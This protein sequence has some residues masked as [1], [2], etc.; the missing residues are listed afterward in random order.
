MVKIGDMMV[1]SKINRPFFV[2]TG[3]LLVGASLFAQDLEI[4]VYTNRTSIPLNEQFELSVELSG[5]DANS[6]PQPSAP[7]IDNFAS[8]VGSGSSTNMQFINGRMSVSKTYTHHYIAIESGKFTVPAVTVNYKGKEY[9]SK[10]FEIEILKSPQQNPPIQGQ[11]RS[12]QKNTTDATE[13]LSN[14]LFLRAEVSNRNVYQ[15]EPVIV[16]YKIYYAVNVGNYGI[17]QLPN[18]VGFW[19]ED[20]ELPGRPKLY[21]EVVNGQQYRVAEIKKVALFAQGSGEK[22]LDPLIIECEV[23][24]PRKRKSRDPF[25]IFDDPFFGFN[26]TA[27]RRVA[28]NAVTINVLP[29]PGE[30]K[31][32]NFSGAVG[33]YTIDTSV[34]K[35]NVKTNEA[36]T[37]KLKLSGTGN[38]KIIPKPEVTFSSDFEVYE[39]KVTDTISRN[40]QQISGSK[41]FEYVLIP[42]FPG[43]QTIKPVTFSYFDIFTGSYKTI[44]SG[45]ID[46]DVAKG[47]EQFVNVGIGNS[48]EDVKFIGQDIRYIQMRLPE[49][50]RIGIVF[51]KSSLFYIAL[52]LPLLTL[53]GAFTYRQH[54]DKLSSD[55]AYARSRK[56][57]QMALQRLKKANYEMH[58]EHQKEF[59]SEVA[60]ALMGFIGDKLN[61]A[62][63]GLIADQ[64]YGMLRERGINKEIVS[65]YLACLQACD[66]QRFAPGESENGSMKEF[67]EKA[68]KAI[69]ALDKEI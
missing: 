4:N 36:I 54:I 48:K 37:F 34:D 63:A 64:V 62:S 25:D 33:N 66:F 14:L 16:S 35:Q 52:I 21:D 5:S 47:D 12:Q 20:F 45:K 44:A 26:R 30:N 24:L 67:F 51:Y 49:F 38:I 32:A 2:L 65:N 27:T 55:V 15:N 68:K 18:T 42:R 61:V 69:I 59:Y 1:G 31:P 56:A 46:L 3:L 19:T 10:P 6:A 50:K 58:K 9:S 57:N 53:A 43:K 29:L 39:P 13:D 41:T 23:Q 7:A 11:Q 8:Y 28:S 40:G 22:K 17:A 60:N